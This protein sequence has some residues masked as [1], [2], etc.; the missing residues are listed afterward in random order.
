[1]FVADHYTQERAIP[2]WYGV[3]YRDPSFRGTVY[4]PVPFNWL[5]QWW[6]SFRFW[7]LSGSGEDAIGQARV[8][9]FQIGYSRGWDVAC[10]AFEQERRARGR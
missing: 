6:R 5:V 4:H 2:W 9:A 1:M 8:E 3:S 10:R 7:V